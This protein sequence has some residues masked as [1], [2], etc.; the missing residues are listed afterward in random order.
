MRLIDADAVLDELN[1]W[2][3]QELYLPIHFKENIIDVLPSASPTQKCVENALNALVIEDIKAEINEGIEN[4]KHKDK[5]VMYG[6]MCALYIIDKH[7]EGWDK[8]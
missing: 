2:D 4:Y 5:A 1:K 8:V 3:W 7:I 6:F